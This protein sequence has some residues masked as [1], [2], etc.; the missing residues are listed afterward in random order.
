MDIK[1]DK[2]NIQK[3]LDELE[4]SLDVIEVQNN[5]TKIDKKYIKKKYKWN[6]KRKSLFCCLWGTI[7]S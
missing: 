7:W 6:S 2:M 1:D 3:A 4:I 5:K